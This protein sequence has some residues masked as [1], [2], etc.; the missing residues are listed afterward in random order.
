LGIAGPGGRTTAGT[1]LLRWQGSNYAYA[2]DVR[3]CADADCASVVQESLGFVG[4]Q[5]EAAPL[6][7]GDYVVQVLARNARGATAA[8]NHGLAF[9]VRAR[10]ELF[11]TADLMSITPNQDYPPSRGSFGS[12]EGADWNC[13]SAA[14]FA[15]LA[16][17]EDWDGEAA[18]F[19]AILSTNSVSAASRIDIS[20]EVINTNGTVLATSKAD[21]FDGSLAAPVDY[22][23]WGQYILFDPD[24]WTG[25]NSIGAWAGDSCGA[26]GNTGLSGRIGDAF[27]ANAGWLSASVTKPCAQVARL[28]CVGPAVLE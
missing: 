14:A 10:H 15:G 20:R 2:Y 1:P 23:E 12:Q 11:A 17:T 5:L 19:K 6:P 25:S 27:V 4:T 7:E 18:L 16:G 24:V 26:W 22:D 8:D 13:T 21:L 3:V 9:S 28:Y